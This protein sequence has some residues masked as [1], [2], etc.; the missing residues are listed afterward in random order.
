MLITPSNKPALEKKQS[1]V[2]DKK[3]QQTQNKDQ[4]NSQPTTLNAGD[5]WK[6][7]LPNCAEKKIGEK[8]ECAKCNK[9]FLLRNKK[10]IK[11]ISECED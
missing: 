7:N 5:N 4:D 2:Y 3:S 9:G 6:K 11:R 1:I 8:L 10:C